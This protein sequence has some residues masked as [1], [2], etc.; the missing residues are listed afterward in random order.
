MSPLGGHSHDHHPAA[1]ESRHRRP[2]RTVTD[3][4]RGT[5]EKK[6]GGGRGRFFSSFLILRFMK[7]DESELK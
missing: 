1:P 3:G 7:D 4:V 2:T 5:K 6:H